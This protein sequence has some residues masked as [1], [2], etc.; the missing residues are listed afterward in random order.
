MIERQA[1]ARYASKAGRAAALFSLCAVLA[2][3]QQAPPGNGAP[4]SGQA[5]ALSPNRSSGKSPAPDKSV[6]TAT[7]TSTTGPTADRDA[8]I[9]PEQA[10]QLFASVD[11]LMRFASQET[12]L[13][14][15]GAVKRRLIS[16]AE[17]QTYLEDK[18]D[19]DQSARRL[20][21]DDLILEK[22]G[23]LDRD[24]QLKP[25]LIA[26][27]KEQIEAFYYPKTKTVNLLDWI[28]PA[29][30]KPVLAHE[31]THALQDQDVGLDKWDHQTPV[32]VSTT[33]PG[34]EEHLERDEM[35]DAR[36]AVIEGQA[37]AVMMDYMLKPLGKSLVK[38]P[39]VLGVLEQHMNGSDSPLLA[40]APLLLSESLLFPYKAGLR[41]EQNLWMDEGQHAAFAGALDRPPTSTWEILNPQAYE[42]KEIPPIPLLPNIHPLVDPLYRAYDIGQVGE[43]DVHVLTELFGGSAAARALTPA[44][45]GGI[46]WAGQ[47]RSATTA[48]EQAS[49]SS[50]AIF[51]LS[52]WR[53]PDAAR[54]FAKLYAANL[55]R[56]YSSVKTVTGWAISGQ[57]DGGSV[58][59]VFSTNE[60]PVLITERGNLVFVAES[61]PL[62]LAR[63]LAAL[64]L[65]AQGSGD[66]RTARN[67]PPA[68]FRIPAQDPGTD[69]TQWIDSCGVM[70]AS[71]DAALRG[72]H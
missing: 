21:H 40:R 50:L 62:P 58:E 72:A 46:Y 8:H 67:A 2:L 59:E 4:S 37:T 35:D 38:N 6:T 64:V 39:E 32:D 19:Q 60:G 51:Y 66:V 49:T 36:D 70:K 68:V 43:L 56:K 45:D 24:F 61:F 22:F 7:S 12:G 41:F 47:L 57:D 52:A 44:W 17:V 42:E 1:R 10:R 5:P 71:V 3:A 48:A 13:P 31:L 28:D 54:A 25:F 55:P 20:E 65:D 69:L 34:D 18:F 33:E 11:Q 15:K 30:Q 23:L 14:I 29:E 9:T 63:K 53:T 27:L 16:R 26:L